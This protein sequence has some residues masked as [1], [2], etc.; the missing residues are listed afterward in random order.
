M[1]SL[2]FNSVWKRYDQ[3]EAVKN[4]DL[5]I[6]DGEFLC[7]LG[8]SGCGKSSSLRMIAG[9]EF[10]SAGDILLGGERIN[11]LEPRHRDIA[12]VFESYALYPQK[13]VYENLAN[14]LRLRKLGK[15]EIDRRVKEAAT[16]LE[17]ERLLE[18]RP[19]QL[20]GGQKQRVAIGRVLVREPK[21]FLFDEPIAHLDAKLRARMRGELKHI[22]KRL[23]TTTVYVTHDQLEGMSMA[24]RIAI[25]RE[26]VLQQVGTPMEVFNEPANVWVA[27]FV[28]DPPMNVLE[29]EMHGG[30][31]GLS[32]V[33]EGFR[34]D[35]PAS[36]A[37]GL[38][39]ADLSDRK[40]LVGVRPEALTLSGT[41]DA[42]HPITGR[43]YAVQPLGDVEVIDVR[44]GKQRLLVR[45]ELG[46]VANEDM[47]ATVYVG[48]RADK[49]HFF[50]PGTGLAIRS[51][52]A[53]QTSVT[54]T[55]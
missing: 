54:T 20:S 37:G 22:Q 52:A 7:L 24:D 53:R 48:Y 33:G 34:L 19:S 2:T 31:G 21:A 3:V 50:H 15:D 30:D 36:R 42:A 13:S 5:E 4:L 6:Q 44:V 51:S 39:D 46:T 32:V 1:A 9:L 43:V 17:I 47:D 14:P 16:T 23:G 10:I 18:R 45:A 26:G 27:T 41:P 12:M 35:V 28:G 8:P 11:D 38:S 25:M 55:A 29:G 40:V 49:L